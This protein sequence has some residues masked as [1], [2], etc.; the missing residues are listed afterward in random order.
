MKKLL[1]SFIAI[2]FLVSGMRAQEGMWLLSQID[3]LNLKEKGLEIETG[4]IYKPDG[5]ALYQAIV[6]LGGGSASF[7]SPDGLIITNHHVAYG[8][9]QRASSAE[10]DYITDGFLARNRE[11]EIQAQGYQARIL[12]QMKD[13]TA[14]IEKAA[15][16]ID[17]PMERDKVISEKIVKMT[18]KAEKGGEDL[19]ADVAEMFNGRQYILFTYKVFKDVRIVYAP[20]ASIGNYGGDIDNWMWPR[21]TGDFSFLRVYATPEGQGVEYAETNVPYHPKVWLKVSEGDLDAG[22]LTFIM[23][24]PG[25]TTRYRT[26]NSAA[27]NLKYNYPFTIETFGHVLEMMDELTENNPEGKIKVAGMKAGLANTMKNYQGKVDGMINTDFV[28][29]K[30][31]FEDEFTDWVISDPERKEKYGHILADIGA[32]YELIKKTK[33]RDNVLGYLRNLGGTELG[34]A[35]YAYY[36]AVE[37]N[38]PKKERKPG[39]D[40]ST[41][42]KV[43]AGLQYQYANLYE[44]LDK[45]MLAYALEMADELPE[46]QRIEPLNYI[47][48]DPDRT[49][50]EFV[51]EAYAKSKLNDIEFAKSLF[52]K[53]PEELADMHDPFIDMIIAVYPLI[54]ENNESYESFAANVTELRKQYIDALY[55]WKG[56]NMYPDANSTLRF[57]S[58]P[59]KGYEP[60]DAVWYKPFTT[61]TG[62]VKKD[63]DKEPFD[64]PD[65]LV[66]LQKENDLGI[67]VDPDLKDVPVAFLHQ[68]DIT[69]GNSGSPVMNARGELIGVAFDGNYEAMISDWQYDYDLQRTISVDIRYVMFITDKFAD[70]DYILEEMGVSTAGFSMK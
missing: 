30:K 70:A 23:G 17:D 53:T 56:E 35:N 18:E 65:K 62:V 10:N 12:Q 25:F 57:T 33:D 29:E 64:A 34:I 16:G 19:Q 39:M 15:K 49:I 22:D 42:E 21:H 27:W 28:A 52:G 24:F 63:R 66:Q 6:Q 44:P 46:G 68:C 2:I 43:K 8:A 59:V 67:Y 47:L 54:E 51:D 5:Q 11:E 7:V 48:D 31:A 37:M 26:S 4:D 3:N 1:L 32:Q 60:A 40:E 36:L 58:G 61:L 9:L 41:L 20:P 14:E 50:V 69:G 55:A 13:V 38:K 45:E